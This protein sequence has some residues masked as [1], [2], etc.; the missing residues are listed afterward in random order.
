M[1]FLSLFFL[2][3]SM[4]LAEAPNKSNLHKARISY[5]LKETKNRRE[6]DGS[7]SMRMYTQDK[8]GTTLVLM[9]IDEL[10]LQEEIDN[11]INKNKHITKWQTLKF[12]KIIFT[13]DDLSIDNTWI[14]CLQN[15]EYVYCE[16]SD[17]ILISTNENKFIHNEKII[18]T[19]QNYSLVVGD[20]LPAKYK[21]DNFA[22]VVDRLSKIQKSEFETDKKFRSRIES[23]TKSYYIFKSDIKFSKNALMMIGVTYDPDL[24]RFHFGTNLN[25]MLYRS[26][27]S[28]GS[29]LG[30]SSSGGAVVI[31]KKFVSVYR[32]VGAGLHGAGF[33]Y[34]VNP[35]IAKRIKNSFYAIFICKFNG[36][37]ECDWSGIGAT[38]DD[39]TEYTGPIR[40]FGIT[41]AKIYIVD[42]NDRAIIGEFS[43]G[44]PDW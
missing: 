9:S 37:A 4:I 18:S 35:L 20:R 33:F 41:S 39:P 14:Y 34:E 16:N 38:S 5:A 2:I 25:D 13:V 28:L 22:T 6:D 8:N 29:K 31:K 24:E 1:K 7:Q 44:Y 11:W 40:T 10:W 15:K 12:D 36:E 23:N 21:F 19:K 30:Y 26:E 32:I 3:C 42:G 43:C 17:T 27:T